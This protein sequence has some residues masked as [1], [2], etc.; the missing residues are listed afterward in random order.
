[1]EPAFSGSSSS[2]AKQGRDIRTV[3]GSDRLTQSVVVTGTCGPLLR[4]FVSSSPERVRTVHRQAL[5]QDDSQSL[6]EPSDLHVVPYARRSSMFLFT[7]T[8]SRR[9]WPVVSAGPNT[10]GTPGPGPETRCLR[11]RAYCRRC[12]LGGARVSPRYPRLSGTLECDVG[13]FHAV[14][15]DHANAQ[16]NI[17][18]LGARDLA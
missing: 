8:T 15:L 14:T 9:S 2:R 6:A 3:L 11:L 18:T 16:S 17:F 13:T 1:M 5:R 4:N 10:L 7:G 12:T